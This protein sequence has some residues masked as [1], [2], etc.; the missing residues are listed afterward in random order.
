L[1]HDAEHVEGAPAFDELVADSHCWGYLCLHREDHELGFAPAELPPPA[2]GVAALTAIERGSS[3]LPPT[4]RIMTPARRW[5]TLHA[6][7][8]RDPPT[9]A[10]SSS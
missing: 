4:V 1:A 10:G 7:R 3:T 5:L 6:F 9:P 2:Y 8:L